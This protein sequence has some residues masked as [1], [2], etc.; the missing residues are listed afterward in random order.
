MNDSKVVFQRVL[1]TYARNETIAPLEAIQVI[2]TLI[3]DS[4]AGVFIDGLGLPASFELIEIA[5]KETLYRL[6][7]GTCVVEL[8]LDFAQVVWTKKYPV[9]VLKS[10]ATSMATKASSAFCV[11]DKSVTTYFASNFVLVL[12]PIDKEIDL[13]KSKKGLYSFNL[14]AL[15][16]TLKA[17]DLSDVDQ[18]KRLKSLFW[19]MLFL[20]VCFHFYSNSQAAIPAISSPVLLEQTAKYRDEPVQAI[21]L[22]LSSVLEDD[23][24]EKEAKSIRE[25]IS[26]YAALVKAELTLDAYL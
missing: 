4:N 7:T 14:H 1:G 21:L 5:K 6:T 3:K 12:T 20:D 17:L 26:K 25:L 10:K 11:V 15:F 13:K 19:E 22:Q 16:E 24:K 2:S 18:I 23:L 8:A 9:L